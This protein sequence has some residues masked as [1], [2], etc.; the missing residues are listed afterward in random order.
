MRKA[1]KGS[2]MGGEE[3]TQPLVSPRLFKLWDTP[4]LGRLAHHPVL[5]ARFVGP[6][7]NHSSCL[8]YSTAA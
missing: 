6:S 7:Q 2:R 3:R 1:G 4:R 5:P 8:H